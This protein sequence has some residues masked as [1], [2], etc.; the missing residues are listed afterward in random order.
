MTLILAPSPLHQ[1]GSSYLI[2]MVISV[3]SPLTLQASLP[4]LPYKRP[5]FEDLGTPGLRI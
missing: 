4:L 3:Y 1:Q 5:C 2:F